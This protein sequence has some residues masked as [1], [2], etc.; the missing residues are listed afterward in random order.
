MDVL[1]ELLRAGL[2][3]VAMAELAQLT[4]GA[5]Q[6]DSG[7]RGGAPAAAIA[8]VQSAASADAASDGDERADSHAAGAGDG[9]RK[10]AT[11]GLSKSAA[12]LA[13]QRLLFEQL[14]GTLSD[15]DISLAAAAS[16]ALPWLLQ[17]F[18]VALR[19]HQA[20][21]AAGAYSCKPS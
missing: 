20:V 3:A 10:Y 17:R 4:K 6:P 2:A 9:G 13:Y 21:A 18:C 8:A 14:R 5:A 19:H 15:T 11:L 12:P 1:F 16:R 7:Q